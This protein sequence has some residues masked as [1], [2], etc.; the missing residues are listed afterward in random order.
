[1]LVKATRDGKRLY[2]MLDD[3]SE[4]NE[5]KIISFIESTVNVSVEC[6]KANVKPVV[7]DLFDDEYII[8]TGIYAGRTPNEVLSNIVNMADEKEVFYEFKKFKNSDEYEE[9]LS[10]QRIFLKN[11]FMDTDAKNY[12]AK[13]TSPKAI[14]MFKTLY[15]EFVGENSSIAE[16]IET[17]K[18]F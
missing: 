12:Q 9:Y 8:P 11:K 1:M 10:A 3:V 13:V 2:L 14:A 6:D 18:N 16:D 17:F 15:S 7:N 5:K 4:D